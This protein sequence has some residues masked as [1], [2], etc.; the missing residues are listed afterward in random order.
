MPQWYISWLESALRPTNSYL[1]EKQ[2]K[3]QKAECLPPQHQQATDSSSSDIAVDLYISYTSQKLVISCQS[4]KNALHKTC[5]IFSTGKKPILTTKSCLWHISRL[6]KNHLPDYFGSSNLWGKGRQYGN[7]DFFE[8][9]IA[10]DDF[11][12]IP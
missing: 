9:G 10:T 11:T 7:Q 2:T 5:Y 3:T 4:D 1:L 12:I 8:A 6:F